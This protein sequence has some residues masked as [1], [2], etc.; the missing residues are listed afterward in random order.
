MNAVKGDDR[1]ALGVQVDGA[2]HAA[3][4]DVP[5]LVGEGGALAVTGALDTVMREP[6]DRLHH[7]LAVGGIVHDARGQGHEDDAVV[8][9]GGVG[10][11]VTRLGAQPVL[12]RVGALGRLGDAEH[13]VQHGRVGGV[14][15]LPEGRAVEAGGGELPLRAHAGLD[16]LA[17]GLGAVA[18]EPEVDDDVGVV[19]DDGRD[20]GAVG[21]CLRVRLSINERGQV[22]Y[23]FK[24]PFR[25]GSTH[26]VLEPLDFIAR[27]AALVPRPR[28]NLTRIHRVFAPNCKHRECVVPKRKPRH[29]KPDKPLAPMTWMQRLKRVVAIDIETCPKCGGTLRVIA[30]IENPDVIATILEHIRV[31]EAATTANPRAPPL[32]T[33]HP[34]A[35]YIG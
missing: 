15:G 3:V 27:L 26:I 35:R 4:V 33:E 2:T 10:E 25:D 18:A 31:R 14:D 30:C 8:V 28:S 5:A 21:G 13:A 20:L 32:N 17:H 11:V 16:Q 7:R 9:L 19:A 34:A 29:E 1:V 12:E 22:I 24:Q 23:R 6:G